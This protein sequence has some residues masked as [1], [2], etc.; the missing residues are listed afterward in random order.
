MYTAIKGVYENGVLRLLEPV[1]GIKKA[2][3]VVT[4]LNEEKSGSK[5][6][7][8][9]G[10][11]LRLQQHKGKHFDIPEDFNDPIDDMKDYM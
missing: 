3:V 8:K 4:F 7:R 9:P 5:K 2:D 6:V 1:R 11:L 10:G